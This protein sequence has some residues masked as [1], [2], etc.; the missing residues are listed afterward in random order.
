MFG[1]VLERLSNV[2]CSVYSSSL[3]LEG[4]FLQSHGS[5]VHIGGPR[6]LCSDA[7]RRMAAVAI[8]RVDVLM[9]KKGRQANLFL[10]LETAAHLGVG[11]GGLPLP[12]TP[13]WK[14]LPHRPTQKHKS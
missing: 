3:S 13:V 9:S 12:F 2:C 6:K 7:R 11:V 8:N 5:A 10:W 4:W 1:S 14:S